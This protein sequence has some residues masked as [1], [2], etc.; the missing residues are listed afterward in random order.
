MAVFFFKE[1]G[2][3]FHLLL[4]TSTELANVALGG[5]YYFLKIPSSYVYE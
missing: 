1:L 3:Y 2:N 4:Q 5:V